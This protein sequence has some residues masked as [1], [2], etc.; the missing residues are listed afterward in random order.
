MTIRRTA[1]DTTHCQGFLLTKHI[2]ALKAANTMGSLNS[3][4]YDMQLV[5]DGDNFRN[6]IPAFTHPLEWEANRL[7]ADIRPFGSWSRHEDDFVI[8]NKTEVEFALLRMRLN[9]VWINQN[10]S[11]LRNLSPLPLRV[12]AS[13]ISESVRRRF[14][15][16]PIEQHRLSILAAILYVSNFH[17][18]D[19]L[20]ETSH[21]RAATGIARDL[22]VLQTE[23]LELLDQ[24]PVIHSV[25]DFCKIA[26]EAASTVRLRELNEGLLY[27]SLGGSWFGVNYKE[28]LAVS[29][30]HPP[31]WI[32]IVYTAAE[33]RSYRQAGIS[34]IFERSAR[35]DDD[36]LFKSALVRLLHDQAPLD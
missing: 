4:A 35:R 8:R 11:Y 33:D 22:G 26:S 6:A 7:A 16:E 5:K 3:V 14:G 27:E 21:I 23:V 15:L 28:I 9:K 17:N 10:A 31:T 2:A 34:R 24:Y 18:E 20:D 29:L 13:W 32:A 1:Y 12:F 25:K 36:K 30:E 19:K